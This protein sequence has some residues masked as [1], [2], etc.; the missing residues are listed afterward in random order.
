VSLLHP[1][2]AEDKMAQAFG[3]FVVGA[4]IAVIGVIVLLVKLL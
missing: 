3:C 4:V 2:T 1:E